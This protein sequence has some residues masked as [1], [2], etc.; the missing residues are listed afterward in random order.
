MMR[1]PRN[2]HIGVTRLISWVK[3]SRKHVFVIGAAIA[4]SMIT[5]SPGVAGSPLQ[6]LPGHYKVCGGHCG[7]VVAVQA[8]ET[9]PPSPS[10]GELNNPEPD[11]APATKN[12]AEENYT[13]LGENDIVETQ[14]SADKDDATE[15]GQPLTKRVK[16]EVDVP[17]PNPLKTEKRTPKGP[18]VEQDRGPSL[19]ERLEAINRLNERASNES[20]DNT[21]ENTVP[22]GRQNVQEKSERFV[23]NQRADLSQDDSPARELATGQQGTE[24]EI[25]LPDKQPEQFFDAP[26]GE[27]LK[28][29]S[30]DPSFARPG[31]GE[32]KKYLAV[33]TVQ[34][35]DSLEAQIE[36]ARRALKLGRYESAL[37]F[38]NRLVQ[39]NPR[40][41]R[42]LM[43]RAI[44]LQKL[45]QQDSAIQA[46]EKLLEVEEGNPEALTN[47]MGLIKG[48]YPEAAL[49]RLTRLHKDHPEKPRVTAQLGLTHAQ[50]GNYEQ[51]LKYLGMAASQER[52]NPQ[53][54]FNMAVIAD[55]KGEIDEAI[56]FYEKALETDA[57]YGSGRSIS[58][59][60]I[61]DR[62]STLR[63]RI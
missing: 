50:L 43:G 55:R 48:K 9:M 18:P 52:N 17:V 62:L 46:Y 20:P 11:G 51:A 19:A 28:G 23:P 41:P 16:P 32:P 15:L 7:Y 3:T 57:I 54:Y 5:S 21:S 42:I 13:P 1:L 26:A 4:W 6:F 36:V 61:Y 29:F 25:A 47:M 40:D 59:E 56:K 45:G 27:S 53:H 2:Q 22:Q 63:Q 60:K 49:R 37:E 39:K 44:A 14:S 35:G 30:N 33:R 12:A 8:D 38:F 34:K 58:R 24:A 10:E 31:E